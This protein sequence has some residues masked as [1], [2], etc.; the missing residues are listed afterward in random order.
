M[1]RYKSSAFIGM[2]RLLEIALAHTAELLAQ[3]WRHAV[4][5][6]GMGVPVTLLSFVSQLNKPSSQKGRLHALR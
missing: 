6:W 4:V 1:T 5:V 2:L 3:G